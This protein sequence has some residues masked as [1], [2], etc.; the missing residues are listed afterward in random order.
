MSYS[1]SVTSHYAGSD[2]HKQGG[3]FVEASEEQVAGTVLGLL[4]IRTGSRV[5]ECSVFKYGN[6]DNL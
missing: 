3:I 1:V 4:S 6:D 2:G 5:T